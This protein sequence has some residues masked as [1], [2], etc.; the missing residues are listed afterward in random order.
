MDLFA[1]I[2]FLAALVLFLIAAFG[3]ALDRVSAGW[4]GAACIALVLL[5]RA[6]GLG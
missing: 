5:V 6:I 2:M 1:A 3:V 4:L